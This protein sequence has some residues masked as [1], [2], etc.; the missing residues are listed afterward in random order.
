VLCGA[1]ERSF[2]VE[3]SESHRA[4][5]LSVLRLVPFV[6]YLKRIFPL[7]PRPGGPRLRIGFW[8]CDCLADAVDPWPPLRATRQCDKLVSVRVLKS[9]LKC[10]EFGL[11]RMDRAG[12]GLWTFWM[13]G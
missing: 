1:I 4:K 12:Y 13:I 3:S 8:T 6:R 5:E 2:L 9:R 7:L 11:A 10:L